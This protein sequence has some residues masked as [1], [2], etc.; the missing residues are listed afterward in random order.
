MTALAL[1]LVLLGPATGGDLVEESFEH[2]ERGEFDEA[3]ET[4]DRAIEGDSDP[5]LLFARGFLLEN[6]QRYEEAIIDYERYLA[7]GP[8]REKAEKAY[9]R[10]QVCRRALEA[11]DETQEEVPE[12]PP[13]VIDGAPDPVQEGTENEPAPRQRPWHRDPLGGVLLGTGSAM[14]VAGG[15]LVGVGASRRLG[16]DGGSTE[17][18]FRQD[19][20]SSTTLQ[21]TGIAVAVTGGLLVGGAALRYMSVKRARMGPEGL[22]IRF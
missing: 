15:I 13:P 9:E 2:F 7:T 1:M 20:Q 3:L 14:L 19:L 11:K 6:L 16:A 5:E 12:P 8:K 17:N 22:A 21:V 4:I 10:I 18:D